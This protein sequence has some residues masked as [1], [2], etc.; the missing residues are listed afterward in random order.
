MA[1]GERLE[2][3]RHCAIPLGELRWRTSR[4]GGPGGQH[5]N[6]S[7]TRVEVIFD[8]VASPSLGPGQRR[9]LRERLGDEVRAVAADERSQARN[10]ALAL[11]RLR[12]RLASALVVTP[13]RRATRPTAGSRRRRLD[14]KRRRSETKRLR[15]PPLD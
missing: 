6:T 12:T 4:S 3:N 15:R 5:A 14:A 1:A 10:R 13:P 9:R 8:V 7:D 11:E 2:V